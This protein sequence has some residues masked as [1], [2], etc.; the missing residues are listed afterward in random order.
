MSSKISTNA[1]K[2]TVLLPILDFTWLSQVWPVKHQVQPLRE[3][4][5]VCSPSPYIKPYIPFPQL[6][7]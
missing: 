7:T 6:H 3:A 4:G 5:Q 2:Q 1:Q